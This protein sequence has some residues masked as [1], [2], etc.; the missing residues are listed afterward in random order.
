MSMKSIL[1]QSRK[2]PLIINDELYIEKTLKYL[3]SNTNLLQQN[4]WK[5]LNTN[6]QK[7]TI[8][9]FMLQ[10]IRENEIKVDKMLK[11]DI[12]TS[13]I[14]I[15]LNGK[16]DVQFHND[17]HRSENGGRSG[18]RGMKKRRKI[19]KIQRKKIDEYG[20]EINEIIE[21]EIE[22]DIDDDDD[23]DENYQKSYTKSYS[24]GETFGQLKMFQDICN[25]NNKYIKLMNQ[26]SSLSSSS[27]I[28]VSNSPNDQYDPFYNTNSTLKFSK[29]SYLRISF[30]DLYN[31]VLGYS[32]NHTNNILNDKIS[33]NEYEELSNKSY[34]DLT[35]YDKELI[36]NY[37]HLKR[38]LSDNLFNFLIY[39]KLIPYNITF[40]NLSYYYSKKNFGNKFCINNNKGGYL[41][42]IIHG[43]IRIDL[44]MN[45]LL[46][47]NESNNKDI[48]K[49]SNKNK[50]KNNKDKEKLNINKNDKDMNNNIK[51]KF[52]IN[53]I[54]C[55]RN[56]NETIKVKVSY[57]FSISH[58]ISLSNLFIFFL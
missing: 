54:S 53:T 8:Q 2:N 37:Y 56:G 29:G 11:N 36:Q 51:K 30:N 32:D 28:P 42:L 40:N 1:L 12:N 44:E 34:N 25:H 31:Y 6:E 26:S 50:D 48:N 13:C 14:Y 27:T 47:N 55:T 35:E 17:E 16:V 39:Y 19:K 3:K 24:T 41:L 22:E 15:I 18:S 21:E 58:S 33:I 43:T 4:F 46:N 10:E 20:N 57:L 5:K 23:D 49:I 52:H 9:Y 38:I 7:K 45:K